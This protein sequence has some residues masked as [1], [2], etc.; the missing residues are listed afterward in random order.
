M[1]IELTPEQDALVQQ[2]MQKGFYRS[3]QEVIKAALVLWE[4]HERARLELVEAL[5]E[6]EDSAARDGW[7]ELDSDEE[8]AEFFEDVK[9]RGRARLAQAG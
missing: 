3:P 1:E 9:R 4:E 2:T 6:G 7:I 8:I 5:Q